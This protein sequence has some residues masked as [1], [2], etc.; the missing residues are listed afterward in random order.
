MTNE[1]LYQAFRSQ[2]K[3][4]KFMDFLEYGIVWEEDEVEDDD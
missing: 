3:Y 1:E 2:D 4:L